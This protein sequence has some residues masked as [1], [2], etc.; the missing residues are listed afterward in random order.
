MALGDTPKCSS[1]DPM[2]VRMSP[3]C[4]ATM[5]RVAVPSVRSRVLQPEGGARCNRSEGAMLQE[6]K[7]R[8]ALGL[9][10]HMS[11]HQHLGALVYQGPVIVAVRRAPIEK[12]LKAMG[13]AESR[14]GGGARRGPTC[15][16]VS[17]V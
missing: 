8:K 12:P 9:T 6:R 14:A 5:R 4:G 10:K 17:Q 2:A 7:N 16:Y 1:P 11:G 13:P 15:E 3:A